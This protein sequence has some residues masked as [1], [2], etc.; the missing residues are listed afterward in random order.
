MHT[1]LTRPKN[2]NDGKL[3]AYVMRTT[4]AFVLVTAILIQ[5]YMTTIQQIRFDPKH[6]NCVH[7]SKEA[8]KFFESLG[9]QTDLVIGLVNKTSKKLEGLTIQDGKILLLYRNSI[10]QEGHAWLLLH[11]GPLNIPFDPSLCMFINPAVLQK[12][13]KII[14]DKGFFH[15]G[16]ERQS[17]FKYINGTYYIATYATGG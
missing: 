4:I 7:M 12:F 6:F 3:I 5:S 17:L 11:I 8:E 1:E 13:S 15:K 10:R 9:I 14:V 16:E 2:K